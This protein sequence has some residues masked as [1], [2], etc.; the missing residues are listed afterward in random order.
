MFNNYFEH[1]FCPLVKI[2][3]P[4]NELQGQTE[5]THPLFWKKKKKEKLFHVF[6]T[7]L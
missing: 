7:F 3:L 6:N 1:F 2:H 4:F 5:S